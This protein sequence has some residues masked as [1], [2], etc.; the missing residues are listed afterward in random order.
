MEFRQPYVPIRYGQ[1]I[2]CK[3]LWPQT[4][5]IQACVRRDGD[6]EGAA[7]TVAIDDNMDE[8]L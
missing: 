4:I 6:S 7:V 1:F 8:M 3:A 5:L 2:S